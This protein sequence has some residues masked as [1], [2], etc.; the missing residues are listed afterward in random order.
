MLML[1]S[2]DDYRYVQLVANAMITVHYILVGSLLLMNKA[3]WIRAPS[4]TSSATAT[5]A[6]TYQSRTSTMCVANVITFS[7]LDSQWSKPTAY[8]V[9]LNAANKNWGSITAFDLASTFNQQTQALDINIR[10]TKHPKSCVEELKLGKLQKKVWQTAHQL[11][12]QPH[13]WMFR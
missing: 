12:S 7:V 4:K 8:H 11:W 5:H 3:C 6:S 2:G 13:A 10:L 9:I 1:H